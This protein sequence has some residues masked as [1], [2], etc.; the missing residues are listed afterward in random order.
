MLVLSVYLVK[1]TNW[2]YISF[3]HDVEDLYALIIVGCG[4]GDLRLRGGDNDLEGRVEVCFSEQWG[5]VCDD[6]WDDIDA[7]VACGQLG[8]PRTGTCIECNY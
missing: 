4:D 6:L 2:L 8:F 1:S 7:N 5:T 3:K